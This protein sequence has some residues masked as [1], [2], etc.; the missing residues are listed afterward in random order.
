MYKSRFGVSE[1]KVLEPNGGATLIHKPTGPIAIESLGEVFETSLDGSQCDS[2]YGDV[3]AICL[4]LDSDGFIYW[5]E[6]IR[7]SSTSPAL[8]QLEGC[9][10]GIAAPP[11][12]PIGLDSSSSSPDPA[13]DSLS[14]RSP[15]TDSVR[16]ASLKTLSCVG[17]GTSIGADTASSPT[18]PSLPAHHQR[19]QQNVKKCRSVSVQMPSFLSTCTVSNI[20]KRKDVPYTTVISEPKPMSTSLPCLD[21]S[22]PLC[23][24]Q[25]WTDLQ[26]QRKG[27]NT[28]SWGGLQ[29][30]LSPGSLRA[31]N[32]EMPL[33][34][35]TV[36]S[37]DPTFMTASN[38][39]WSTDTLPVSATSFQSNSMSLV[40]TSG[41]WPEDED[42]DSDIKIGKLKDRLEEKLW[43]GP[44]VNHKSCCYSCDGHH[45][46]AQTHLNRQPSAQNLPYSLDELE[47]MICCLQKFR[48]VLADI[49][50]QVSED[51]ATVFNA[52]SETDREEVCD[53]TEL[54][55]AVK[56]EAVELE[57]QL[58]ELAHHYDENFKM[59]M[60]RLLTEQSLLCS[61]LRLLPPPVAI[62]PAESAT[63][64][65]SISTQCSLPTFS[66]VQPHTSTDASEVELPPLPE[67]LAIDSP[68]LGSSATKPDKL[69]FVGF[70][71]R[72]RG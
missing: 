9:W 36:F 27:L 22:T 31:V 33:S 46:C 58:T 42:E 69:D 70:L 57:L 66:V 39:H 51:Q 45:T 14:S 5:A 30:S 7:V 40:G 28:T 55:K 41:L 10:A 65:Q 32:T 71:Q 56:Q 63:P 49:E 60:H 12:G 50:E 15:E 25:S 23:A 38:S 19:S 47:G 26:L 13:I 44:L 1:D 62:S 3:D 54:R 37:S 18:S 53:I 11:A 16:N 17:A 20:I 4:E 61:H 67:C 8:N 59:K 64:T 34:P 68:M 43:E 2:E 48:V 72:V 21:T 24:V 29:A 35:T 6:P 52:L